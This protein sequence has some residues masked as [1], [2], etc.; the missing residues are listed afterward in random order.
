LAFGLQHNGEVAHAGGWSLVYLGETAEGMALLNEAMVAVT[1]GEVSPIL[2]GDVYC[3]V[4][5]ACQ[6]VFDLRR[7]QVWTAPLSHWCASQ[8]DLVLYRGQC[9]M[10]R[11]EIMQLHGTWLDAVDEAQRACERLSN[12]TAQPAVGAA[13]YQQAELQRLRGEFA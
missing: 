12:P 11:A 2:V 8:P 9:L 7:A 3:S 13:F 6:E 10:H 5:E 1:A 4:I